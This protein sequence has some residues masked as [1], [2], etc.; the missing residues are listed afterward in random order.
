MILPG[1]WCSGMFL[2]YA[3]LLIDQIH[4]I[5]SVYSL[6]LPIIYLLCFYGKVD[7]AEYIGVCGITLYWGRYSNIFII[8]SVILITRLFSLL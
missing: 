3:F 8:T 4:F 2:A 5:L 1:V 7:Y 6:C